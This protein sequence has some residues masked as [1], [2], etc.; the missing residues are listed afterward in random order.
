MGAEDR[1]GED[2]FNNRLDDLHQKFRDANFHDPS[3]RQ[4]YLELSKALYQEPCDFLRGLGKLRIHGNA[5][6]CTLEKNEGDDLL[7][8]YLYKGERSVRKRVKGDMENRVV[9]D[10]SVVGEDVWRAMQNIY[11]FDQKMQQIELSWDIAEHPE[12]Y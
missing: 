3:V 6:G 5:A 10:N 11:D 7:E 1:M 9:C 2:D 8:I 12:D 4:R